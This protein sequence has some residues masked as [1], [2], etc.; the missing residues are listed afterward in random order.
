MKASDRKKEEVCIAKEKRAVKSGEGKYAI[1]RDD[2]IRA[3]SEGDEVGCSLTSS[4]I[5]GFTEII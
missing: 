3:F 1:S 5:I 2:V 4:R